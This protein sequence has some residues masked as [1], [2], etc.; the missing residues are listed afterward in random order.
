MLLNAHSKSQTGNLLYCKTRGRTSCC[1]EKEECV[2]SYNVVN[3]AVRKTF[4][5]DGSL[6]K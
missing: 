4:E 2:K 6:N 1:F 5:I 3:D